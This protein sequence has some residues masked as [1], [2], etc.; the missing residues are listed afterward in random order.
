[1]GWSPDW[2][3]DRVAGTGFD[4]RL[5]YDDRKVHARGTIPMALKR[6]DGPIR[7]FL[8]RALE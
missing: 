2:T 4:V 1:M 8:A 7:A 6:L 5:C 3:A